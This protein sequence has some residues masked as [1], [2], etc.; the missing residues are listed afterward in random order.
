ME[1]SQL[2]TVLWLRWRLTKNQWAR[3]GQVSAA[4][5]LAVVVIVSVVGLAGSLAGVLLGVLRLADEPPRTLLLVWDGLI[6]AFLFFWIIGVVSNIQRS[7]TIDMGKMLH[8][9]VS[10]RGLFLIN[11]LASHLTLS[12]AL[13]LPGMLGLT[14]GLAL[15][16][17]IAMLALLPL[18]VGCLFMI[19]AWTYCLRGWLVTLMVNPR[20]RRA[21]IAMVTFLFILIVQLPN[22]AGNLMARQQRQGRPA[23]VA[24]PEASETPRSPT[25][26]DET[27][28]NQWVD[29][30]HRVVPFLWPAQGA[31]C[32]AQ[33]R[34]GPALWGSAGTLL[35]GSL[36]LARA[37][38]T[39]IRFYGG[40]GTATTKKRRRQKP[41]RAR[42]VSRSARSFLEIRLPGVSGE[43][44]A[45]ALASFRSMMRAPEIKM[46]LG[47]NVLIL[48]FLGMMT[49]FGETKRPDAAFKP[50]VVTLAVAVTY[51]GLLQLMFN[52][53]GHDRNGFRTLVLVPAQR[54]HILLGKNIALIPFVLG[55]GGI[56][57]LLV[58]ILV[59]IPFLIV[60]AGALQL[61]T[62]FLSVSLLG[63]LLS[64]LLPY[65]VA[66]GSMKPTKTA[67][68]VT[69]LIFLSHMLFPLAIAPL[70]LVPLLG[71]LLG[72]L[73][74]L[75][76]G[77]I[78]C[79]LAALILG[80]FVV[81]YGISL[82]PLGRLL[83]R[84]EQKILEVVTQEVE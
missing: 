44:A 60:V 22:L 1:T 42:Q 58:Q 5:S 46:M 38:R 81:L 36:G 43:A 62:A 16:R 65:R 17:G 53:F 24:A 25:V 66:A 9:P 76:M 52:Q 67:A 61:L 32:L 12:I 47:T 84:R 49:L 57:L 29:T 73:D 33:G 51:F 21:V 59:A 19:T 23:I 11:F 8:L 13:F 10:L 4:L 77:V 45:L 64:I 6:F 30:A 20:R 75:P 18:I 39:T 83:G 72:K 3:G 56:F 79:L 68:T 48:F 14:L 80:V 2:R 54:T 74:W 7:E 50:L 55:I 37:Y 71:W 78:H 41:K 70:F 69:F 28:R 26:S 31:M 40:V 63:N 34:V 82:P 15:G 35:L 27:G